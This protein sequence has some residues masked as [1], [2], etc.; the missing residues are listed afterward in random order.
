V[1]VT[2][3]SS[4][5]TATASRNDQEKSRCHYKHRYRKNAVGHRHSVNPNWNKVPNEFDLN[6][7]LDGADVV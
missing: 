1:S 2:A 4:A 5:P 3:N 7:S 6:Q